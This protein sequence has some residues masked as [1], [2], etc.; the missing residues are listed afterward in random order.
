MNMRIRCIP[1]FILLLCAL[2]AAASPY[3]F[4]SMDARE[5]LSQNTVNAIVEDGGGFMWFGTKDGLNR[6][7]GSG[8]R[9]FR[10]DPSDE[11]GLC[12]NFIRALVEDANGDLWIG[13]DNG[14]D[15]YVQDRLSG[16]GL[17]LLGDIAHAGDCQH[18]VFA[19]GDGEPAV[20]VGHGAVRGA[21]LEDAGSYDGKPAVIDDGSADGHSFRLDGLHLQLGG[22]QSGRTGA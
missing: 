10:H 22:P 17:D 13:T 21:L 19:Y 9:I 11:S 5:G 4:K 12:N 15:V 7:D 3:Y 14:L 16:T 6:Y 2:Q 18:R 8:F 1:A 20:D